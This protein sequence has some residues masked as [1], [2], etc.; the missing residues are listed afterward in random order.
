MANACRCSGRATD[1]LIF[2]SSLVVIA[3][4]IAATVLNTVVMLY[5]HSF[6]SA[7]KE[8]SG[9]RRC[10]A[11]REITP[12]VGWF[13]IAEEKNP[14]DGPVNGVESERGEEK[15]RLGRSAF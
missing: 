3:V 15:G 11:E 1:Y 10:L 12:T 8:E 7:A 9:T 13:R 4:A 14:G 6:P 2:L 5:L